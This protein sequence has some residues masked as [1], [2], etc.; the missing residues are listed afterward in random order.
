MEPRATSA[1]IP[2]WTRR[3][4]SFSTRPLT[5]S[6]SPCGLS[7]RATSFY[8]GE[9]RPEALDTTKPRHKIALVDI[10]VGETV[11]K[12][13]HAIGIATSRIAAGEHVHVHNLAVPPATQAAALATTK[14]RTPWHP[15]VEAKRTSFLGF[16]RR[17]GRV[18]T[19][20][21][22]G[23]LPSVNCAATVG[24]L[25]ATA[26]APRLAG[27]PSCD[28][29]IALVHDLGC[30]MAQGTT[31]DDLLRRTL[32]G[33]ATHPNLA[34]VIVVTLG[35]EVNQPEN[36]LDGS[37]AHVEHL[38]IQELGGTNATVAAIVERVGAIAESLEQLELASRCRPASSHARV[39]WWR[40]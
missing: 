33:Y 14:P 34:A 38:S 11:R 24:R 37:A 15:G 1:P 2:P 32:R 18:G 4:S 22:I 12:L 20:N 28:G 9:A 5:T 17:D 8:G 13:G 6:E 35:C 31:E 3:P 25:A 40:K 7:R 30:G 27:V 16:R 23:I 21:Y 36:F 26:A 19:R 29:V 10:D 39:Q